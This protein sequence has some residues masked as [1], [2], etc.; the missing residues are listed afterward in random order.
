MAKHQCL[1]LFNAYKTVQ[2]TKEYLVKVGHRFAYNDTTYGFKFEAELDNDGILAIDIQLI[3]Q[4]LGLRS[5]QHGS[6]LYAQMIQHFGLEKIK[7]ITGV[8]GE[9]TNF[10]K[11]YANLRN[12]MSV[13][14]AALNTWSGRQAALYGFTKIASYEF[15]K[16]EESEFGDIPYPIHRRPFSVLFTRP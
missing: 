13:E 4:K 3:D 9:G 1:E 7:G 2:G 14:D 6:Q 8:W 16:V 5:Y 12:R 10:D 11:F 15:T